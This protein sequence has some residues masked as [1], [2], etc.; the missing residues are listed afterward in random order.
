MFR[1]WLRTISKFG[2]KVLSAVSA[3]IAIEALHKRRDIEL[4]MSDIVMPGMSG[5]ELGGLIR[6]RHPNIPVILRL[7]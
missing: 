4:V 6:E 5:L 1:W 3:E 2:C 7:Q